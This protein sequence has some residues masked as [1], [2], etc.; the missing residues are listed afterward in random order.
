MSTARSFC[1]RSC[2]RRLSVPLTIGLGISFAFCL[3]TNPTPAAAA[4]VSSSVAPSIYWGAAIGYSNMGWVPADMSPVSLF[5][6]HAGKGVSIIHLGQAWASGGVFNAFN[7]QYFD[8]I[9][10]HGSIPFFTW[11]SSDSGGSSQPNFRNQVITGGTYDAYITNW[12]KAAKAWGH[13]FFLRFDHEMDGWWYP[14]GEGQTS[15]GGA[16]VNGNQPGDYVRMW[17]HVHDIFTSVGATNVTWVWCTNHEST[18]SQY[19]AMSQIYPGD[20]YVDWTAMDPYNRYEGSWL[21]FNQTL[22]GAGTTWLSDTYGKLTGVAPTKPMIISE[23]ASVESATDPLAKASQS[24]PHRG[25]VGRRGPQRARLE[26]YSRRT[27]P[28]ATATRASSPSTTP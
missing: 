18:S 6:S 22:T 11:M 8:N 28:P 14:W 1:S 17:R 27:P 5:E 13:P 7:T 24:L 23:F 25:R 19:P 12:A 4:Q 16:T 3:A 15:P 26:T 20:N 2:I 10:N 9:R 21:S